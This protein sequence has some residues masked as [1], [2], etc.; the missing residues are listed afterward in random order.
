MAATLNI[1]HLKTMKT[2][3]RSVAHDD[4]LGPES[5]SQIDL[6]S[7]SD[8][9]LHQCK[10]HQGIITTPLSP[11]LWRCQRLSLGF[12]GNWRFSDR[13]LHRLYNYRNCWVFANGQVL[14]PK[15][16]RPL[17]RYRGVFPVEWCCQYASGLLGPLCSVAYGVAGEDYR[18]A[19]MYFDGTFYAWWFVS[20]V[21]IWD[22]NRSCG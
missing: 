16:A 14:E 11:N 21:E 4:L 10:F 19:E 15:P 9:I 18:P 22:K 8:C 1:S 20:L 13:I 5:N 17:Y 6:L 3:S 2:F 7:R 12:V